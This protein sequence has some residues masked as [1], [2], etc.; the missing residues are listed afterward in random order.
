MHIG[1]T[2]ILSGSGVCFLVGQYQHCVVD[3]GQITSFLSLDPN[4][5]DCRFSDCRHQSS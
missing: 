4:C 1:V 3:F 2:V 5:H